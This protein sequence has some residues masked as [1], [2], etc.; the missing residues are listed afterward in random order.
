MTMGNAQGA[1][2]PKIKG[3]V[4]KDPRDWM[5][6][7]YGADAYNAALAKLSEPERAFVDGP[8]LA[9]SFYPLEAWDRFQAAMRAEA[10][11]RRG[12][13]ALQFSMRNMR[14][15]GSAIVRGV[16][17]FLLGLVSPEN[18]VGKFVVVY[19]RVYSEGHCEI[20]S[21]EKG[22]VV[23]RYC[24]ANPAFRTNLTHNFLASA[25]FILELNGATGI[26]GHVSRDEVVE[27]K[28]VFEV[29]VTFRS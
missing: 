25:M 14:E 20:V 6:T 19:N 9:G 16:Y 2:E 23:L 27:G 10:M 12:H 17:K 7:A 4:I 28:L 11:A 3:A 21:N 24:D 26:D 13:N 15:A 18:A 29:T 5:R 1:G 8:I 22:R